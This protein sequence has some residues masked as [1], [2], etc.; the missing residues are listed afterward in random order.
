M[1][2]EGTVVCGAT[3][4]QCKCDLPPGH[5]MP[6]ECKDKQGCGGAWNGTYSETDRS[7]FEIVRLPVI[8]AAVRG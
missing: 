5:P 8:G 3:A 1:I 2:T 7:D 4:A 6:H